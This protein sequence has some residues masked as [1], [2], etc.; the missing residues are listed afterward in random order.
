MTTQSEPYPRV[1]FLIDKFSNWLKHRR[2]LNEM[3]QLDRADFDRIAADLEISPSDLDELVRRGPHAGK[4]LPV[5][6]KA[7]G[8]G[9]VRLERTQ[10][11]LLRDME[12]VCA[13]CSH[14]RQCDRDLIDGT[15]VGHY[16]GYCPNAPAIAELEATAK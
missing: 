12:R 1:N 4:E 16:E 6:L 14:K 3:R 9:E 7:L 2:E 8:I 5:L 11:H 13:M 10:P 15:S